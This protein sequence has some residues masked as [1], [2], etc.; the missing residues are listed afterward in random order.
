MA[1][2][3]L[4]GGREPWPGDCSFSPSPAVYISGPSQDGESRN[5]SQ[6]RSPS[7]R[8]CSTGNVPRS[9]HHLW[10]KRFS[11]HEVCIVNGKRENTLYLIFL[12]VVVVH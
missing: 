11:L 5:S 8:L 12:F 9:P 2:E 4:E 1:S 3:C 10:R 6:V 7:L